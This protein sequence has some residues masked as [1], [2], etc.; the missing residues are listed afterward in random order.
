[1]WRPPD[2]WFRGAAAQA[3]ATPQCTNGELVAKYQATDA[4]MSHQFG[5]IILTNV[6]DHNCKI[7]GYGG[8]CTN[9]DLVATYRATDAGMSHRFGRIVLTNVSARV[10]HG[11]TASVVRRRR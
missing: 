1:M 4:G 7:G 5:R 9:G 6:S 11:A 10:P 3:A 8:I 2:S